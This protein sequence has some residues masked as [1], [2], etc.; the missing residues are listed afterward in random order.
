MRQGLAQCANQRPKPLSQSHE[1]VVSRRR[2]QRRL[3]L[4]LEPLPKQSRRI[5]P[6]LPFTEETSKLLF[7]IVKRG[8]EER[9]AIERRR[10]DY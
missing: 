1:A 10:A 5:Q 3:G 6:L 7:E 9:L 8:L 2:K 4:P